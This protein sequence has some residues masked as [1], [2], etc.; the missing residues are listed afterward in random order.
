MTSDV[1]VDC[2]KDLSEES[3]KRYV[4]RKKIVAICRG[5]SEG[6]KYQES[7]KFNLRPLGFPKVQGGKQAPGRYE[8][9]D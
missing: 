2:G 1:C 9:S 8:W 6:N 3:R 5:C 4:F 7:A